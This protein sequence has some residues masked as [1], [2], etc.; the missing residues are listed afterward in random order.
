MERVGLK[1]LQKDENG[2]A[3]TPWL[4]FQIRLFWVD[5]AMPQHLACEI[6]TL[7]PFWL[8]NLSCKWSIWRGRKN[9]DMSPADRAMKL[10][11]KKDE[12]SGP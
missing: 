12:A 10:H 9:F 7:W 8:M 5:K 3:K 4:G 11:E 2:M 6:S 1:F